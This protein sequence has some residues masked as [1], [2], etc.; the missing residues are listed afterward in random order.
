M[1]PAD[2]DRP[3]PPD[4]ADGELQGP[5]PAALAAAP[6]PGDAR[7]SRRL[8]TLV[9]VQTV[10][11]VA[12]A[13]AVAWLGRDEFRL[14]V[15]READEVPVASHL[16]DAAE[17]PPAVLLGR[18]AQQR[19]GLAVAAPL[20]ARL[21]LREPHWLSVV[22]PQPLAQAREQLRLARAAVAQAAATA[23]ASEAER[24]RVQALFDDDRNASQ[25]QLE[26]ARAQARIDQAQA[27]AAE[28]RL[29]GQQEALRAAWGRELAASVE[30]GGPRAADRGR[31]D[32][33]TA[34]PATADRVAALLAGRL[35]LLRL[36][37]PA[38]VADPP[39]AR[40]ELPPARPGPVPPAAAAAAEA[41][42]PARSPDAPP[43]RIARR[44]AALPAG[45]GAAPEASA[46]GRQWLYLA[47][48]GGLAVG[49]RLLAHGAGDGAAREGLL[50]PAAAI[51][52][53][54]GQPWIYVR[55]SG[56]DED[57][58]A[59]AAPAPASP[60]ASM[61]GAGAA[62]RPAEAVAK[63]RFQRRALPAARRVGEQWFVPG[64][65]EDDPVVVRGAQ[66][67]LSEELKSQIRN[68]NDD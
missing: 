16:D 30:P 34:G 46:G 28:A 18:R 58:G 27:R 59:E 67:L 48:G 53:H 15:G 47:P 14:A 68:E 13:W 5:P 20:E 17:G 12:L 3:A 4:G 57:E 41:D 2:D 39:P 62:A 43:G 42:G 63:D 6:L 19:L 33:T 61:P 56:R 50:V 25:R 9:F 49:Q 51:V 38:D 10:L 37:Q 64:L 54:A 24:Q 32:A 66:V 7:T 29:E 40:L 45:A 52:W 21:S 44:L 11:I 23:Q 22:D 36:V 1:S 60:S 55:E 65:S 31:A 8:A 35:V 26:Q